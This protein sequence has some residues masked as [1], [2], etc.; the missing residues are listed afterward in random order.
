[1]AVIEKF[2]SSMIVIR[3][4]GIVPVPKKVLQ[5]RRQTQEV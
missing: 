5:I 4:P 1:M 3:E 2:D